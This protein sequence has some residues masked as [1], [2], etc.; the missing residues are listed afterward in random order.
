MSNL[1][2]REH[3]PH[4]VEQSV[5]WLYAFDIHCNSLFPTFLLLEVLH[6]FLLPVLLSSSYTSIFLSNILFLLGG[7]V[8][9]SITFLGYSGEIFSRFLTRCSTAVYSPIDSIS[10][11]SSDLFH[12][13]LNSSGHGHQS[14]YCI[15]NNA[16]ILTLLYKSYPDLGFYAV[17]YEIMNRQR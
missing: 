17:R 5:E 12:C 10:C 7:I 1:Y 13:V 16:F 9:M 14:L 11:P 6:Y 3:L 4:G 2:L 8:Y 15:C